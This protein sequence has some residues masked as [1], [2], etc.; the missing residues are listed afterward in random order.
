VAPTERSEKI[1]AARDSK[2]N[3]LAALRPDGGYLGVVESPSAT[4]E[5]W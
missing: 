2:A 5:V 4:Q 1:Y 3:E